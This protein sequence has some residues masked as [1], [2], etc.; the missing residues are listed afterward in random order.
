MISLDSLNCNFVREPLISPFG[1]K[2]GYLSELWQTVVGIKSGEYSGFGV[3]VQSVLWSDSSVFAS[4]SQSAGNMLM[5]LTT[6]YAKTRLSNVGFETPVDALEYIRHDTFEYAKRITGNSNLRQTFVLNSL[7]PVDN[8]LW[9]IYAKKLQTNS[10]MDVVPKEYSAP[11]CCHH[12]RLGSIP[13]ITYGLSEDSIRSLLNDGHFILKIK[14]GSDPEHDNDLDKM[15]EWDKKRL[16]Q[17][18][19]IASEYSTEYTENGK[20][21]YYIDANG[22]YDSRDRLNRLLDFADSIDAASQIVILEEPFAEEN[23]IDVSDIP[24]RIA[25]DESAHSVKDVKERT[26]LG[27]SA[28]A[29][30]PIAK[31][32]SETLGILSEAYKNNVPCFCADLTVNPI[33]AEINKNIAARIA[34]IPGLK[35]GVV[36]VNGGQNYK[37]WDKMF[38][39]HPLGN[40]AFTKDK[41][42]IFTLDEEFYKTSGGI[43]M[44]SD[45]Y[46]DIAN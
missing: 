29:L 37:N 8:A 2:G 15:L 14:I 5:F 31:T 33:M 34:P 18:H 28:I 7:V 3:G 35:I 42:G 23:K 44:D 1:F 4:Y 17:I 41:N 40:S 32:L 22:R 16:A 24:C 20:I 21:A 39:Y 11:L 25:A 10:F 12:E 13:L 27:Y 43:Y 38:S 26:E 45:Y 30:K 6:E 46:N 36:E 19:K 9:Q